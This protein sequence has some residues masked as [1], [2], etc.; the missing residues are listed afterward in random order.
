MFA[1][2]TVVAGRY[3]LEEPIGEGGMA[4]VWRAVQLPLDR[5]VALKFVQVSHVRG[6]ELVE[7]FLRE[8]KVLAAASHRNTVD[9]IDFGLT[10]SQQPFMVMELL[11][12]ETLAEK[13]D[14]ERYISIAE[15]GPIIS[16]VLSGLS[17]VHGA[18]IVHRDIKPD[19][20]F[21]VKDHEGIHPKLLDFGVARI[22][23]KAA[24]MR[25]AIPTSDG[26]IVGTPQYMSSEQARGLADIDRRADIYG[27]GVLVYRTLTGVLPYD[28]E[29]IGDL[30]MLVT[31]GNH[32]PFAELRPDLE[33]T[34]APIVEKAMAKK[35]EDRFQEAT[36][37]RAAWESALE[38]VREVQGQPGA[39]PPS[40]VDL[41]SILIAEPKTG[42][43][44]G[45]TWAKPA[46]IG[47]VLL[48][49]IGA[50][51]Y[52]VLSHNASSDKNSDTITAPPIAAP[53]R[54]NIDVILEGV[55]N[56][57]VV[58]IDG[59]EE[60]FQRR[61]D[62]S[63]KLEMPSAQKTR[64]I[65]VKRSDGA[66]WQTDHFASASGV[67]R[68]AFDPPTLPTELVDPDIQEKAE[69]T[70]KVERKERAVKHVVAAREMK[71][72]RKKTSQPKPRA[73]ETK[74]AA[75]QK[76]KGT[77]SQSAPNVTAPKQSKSLFD[78]LGN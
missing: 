48:A 35:R 18:G 61:E 28:H 24:G 50:A 70:P 53:A 58:M 21:L 38:E 52:G 59:V 54:R 43:W 68:M 31:S 41:G 73:P 22:V 49:G 36:E 40:F 10:E 33:D 2:G 45:R 27:V 72:T 5:P 77:P 26:L 3:R 20:V 56:D 42:A 11:Q 71:A 63:L 51:M 30:I 46:L 25:S 78:K 23:N 16:G 69:P 8:A 9:V 75:E 6:N 29:N 32:K 67:Y 17:A 44:L 14:R 4:T 47:V 15:M 66:T 19:N 62:G 12:G 55:P 7:Q 60:K 13:L 76:T 74:P 34:I 37:M 39:R 65:E 64:R 57:A 1:S